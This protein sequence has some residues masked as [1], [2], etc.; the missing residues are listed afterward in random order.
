MKSFIS[1][2]SIR[3][4]LLMGFGLM[5]SLLL[6][7]VAVSWLT[8]NQVQSHAQ[9]I[10][11]MYEPQVDRMTRVE[12]LMVKISLEARQTILAANDP[13]ELQAALQRINEDREELVELIN[14]T[15]AN[16]STDIGRDIMNNIRAA[17]AEFWRLS[18]EVTGHAQ[19]R[20]VDAA[21]ALLTTD[22]V[23]A[24]NRQLEHIGEQKEW[25]RQL[26][27]DTLADTNTTIA[28]FKMVLAVVITGVLVLISLLLLRLI[29][30]ITRPL[31]S[32][33]NTIVQVEHSG[34]Y[35]QRVAV[36]GD[37][38]VARTAA[39]FDRMM[40][41]IEQR[42]NELA[43]NREHLE[44]I[45]EQRTAELSQAVAS[46]E[47]ANQAKSRFLATMSH[48]LRT[49]M[50]GVLGM[51][52]L[53]LA[54]ST[55][56]A[57]TQEYARTILQSGQSLLTLLND[58]LDLSKIESGTQTLHDG[59][60]SPVELLQ[61]NVALFSSI[62]QSKG[63]AL[64]VHWHG[65]ANG[66]YRGDPNRLQQMLTNLSNN[67]IK[68]TSEGEISI[69]AKEVA[70]EGGVARLEFSVRDTGIGVP[71]HKHALL[72]RPFS[73]IDDSSTRQFGGTGLG[74]SIVKSLAQLMDG[75]VGLE[76]QEG[77]GSRFWFRVRL[78]VLPDVTDTQA[79]TFSTSNHGQQP[80]IQRQLTGLV[81]LVED[82]KTNQMVAVA[83]LKKL[84]LDVVVA[85]NGQMAVDLVTSGQCQPHAILMDIQMPVLDGYGATA[86]LREWET[87]TSRPPLPIIALTAGAF[88]EDRTS[89]LEAGMND[90]L[91]KPFKIGELADTLARWLQKETA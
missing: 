21:Y 71:A 53:L 37:D 91:S 32:L 82:H 1:R 69:E 20:N 79:Q 27:N 43:R 76:S 57:Q 49:P 11:D 28:S 86:K 85:D 70:V 25:Q 3:F 87:Q 77:Q 14:E 75:D 64:K 45:V 17:D 50:N 5:G 24:R 90:Y 36:K 35:T 73:Q 30:A 16:L 51:A 33:L 78:E 10:I 60:V 66:R 47:S 8:L 46:A 9:Q 39:A 58:I 23:P 42:T 88:A 38:E 59:V 15:E 81:L 19:T 74:L 68:F 34:D 65:P 54:E 83:L 41:L 84:G 89:C 44:E 52:Q 40:E 56:K 18:R 6:G 7:V 63:L 31:T 48:E 80:L 13:P 62:A 2:L 22:L 61:S 12:L 72:F 29:N 26:M 4:R 55:D 67:A